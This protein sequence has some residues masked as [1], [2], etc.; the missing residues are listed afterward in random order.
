MTALGGAVGDR[1]AHEVPAARSAVSRPSVEAILVG[2]TPPPVNGQSVAFQNLVD[3]L[4]ERGVAV[5]VVDISA[6][7]DE[8]ST[9]R[10]WA[11]RLTRAMRLV[12]RLLTL[13]RSNA[14]VVYLTAAQSWPGFI[15]DSLIVAWA[16]ATRRTVVWHLHGGN[17]GAFYR[18]L[19]ARRQRIVTAVLRRVAALIVLDERFIRELPDDVIRSRAVVVPNGIPRPDLG[20]GPQ[21][22]R[23]PDNGDTPVRILYM[24]N[25][26]RSKGYLDVLDAVEILTKERG[27]DVRADFCGVFA[28]VPEEEGQWLGRDVAAAQFVEAIERKGLDGVVEWRRLTTGAD[29]ARELRDAHFLVLP[30]AYPNEG[31]PLAVIEGLA[32]GCV[33]LATDYR[34]IPALLDGG[35]AGRFVEHGDPRSIADR[36]EELCNDPAAYADASR[37]AHEHFLAHYQLDRHL[38]AVAE[39]FVK[40]AGRGA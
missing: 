18:S 21:A 4:P 24:S 34:G 23:L 31:Q 5:E 28:W 27:I 33:V 11:K 14:G 25:L 20:S 15:R 9:V 13:S 29:K 12:S 16:R 37:R 19:G 39:I 7:I 3:H 6:P 40:V 36:V 22:K 38:D 32:Y 30:T 26:V 8:A 10:L 1:I 35:V 17:Y 2:A